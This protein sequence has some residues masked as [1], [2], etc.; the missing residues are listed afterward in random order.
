MDVGRG[1]VAHV[2]YQEERM[3][4]FDE[5]KVREAGGT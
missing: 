2:A 5:L 1:R 4:R 3:R